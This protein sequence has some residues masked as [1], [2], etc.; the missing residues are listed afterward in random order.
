MVTFNY[1]RVA[2]HK[3]SQVLWPQCGSHAASLLP[4]TCQ[5]NA[6]DKL[7]LIIYYCVKTITLTSLEIPF[8]VEHK[9]LQYKEINITISTAAQKM[10]VLM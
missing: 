5:G 4:W 10:K 9:H 2:Q 6:S 7:V 3:H 1:L 8:D